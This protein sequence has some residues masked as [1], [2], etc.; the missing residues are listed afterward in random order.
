MVTTTVSEL[1]PADEPRVRLT[2]EQLFERI[3]S[4]NPTATVGFLSE[5][6][7]EP[8][9][10]YLDHLLA[11][12]EPRGRGARWSRPGDAPAIVGRVAV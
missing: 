4:L 5:F 1:H 9:R 3:M 7:E 8:L 6:D 2:R 12:Q 11:A 10:N